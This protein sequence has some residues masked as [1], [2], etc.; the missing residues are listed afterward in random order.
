[1]VTEI[2]M[3]MKGGLDPRNK[4][5]ELT[6]SR[7]LYFT[8][9]VSWE[10]Y[11]SEYG[12]ELR[13]KHHANKPP[14]LMREIIEFFTKPHQIILD[15]FAGVGG[16]LIG[17]SLCNRNAV[18]IEINK[19][20]IDIYRRVCASESIRE[21]K[22]IHGDCLEV[23][24]EFEDEGRVFDAVI[25]DPPYAPSI[26]RTLCNGGKTSSN[27]FSKNPKCFG[28]LRSFDKY[29]LKME[30][31]GRSVYRILKD[32]K[33]LVLMMQDAYQNGRYIPTSFHV[34]ER[35]SRVGFT[36]KGV[37]IWHQIGSPPLRPYG[38]PYSYVPNIIHHNILIF[39]R[40]R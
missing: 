21:Q 18:G 15:P 28:N 37:K 27:A 14:Q 23:L 36:F 2:L 38:Y 30:Q 10:V 32:G 20:W 6:V 24:A 31:L 7:W 13:K 19:R 9:T 4:L 26:K 16:T 25:T 22:M 11:P 8:K 1:M 39:K 35:M 40:G 34:A 12:H 5:N 33:Y 29:Y 3:K 17:A